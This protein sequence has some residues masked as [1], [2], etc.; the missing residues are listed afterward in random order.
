MKPI[1]EHAIFKRSKGVTMN[2]FA[3]TICLFAM[4]VTFLGI[5]LQPQSGRAVAGQSEYVQP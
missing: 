1:P 2:K 3:K 5:V 4:A